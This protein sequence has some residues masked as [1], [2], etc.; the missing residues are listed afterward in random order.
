[1]SNKKIQGRKTPMV[2]PRDKIRLSPTVRIFGK[3]PGYAFKTDQTENSLYQ[4]IERS[5]QS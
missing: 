5:K 3:G 2:I 1:M 4:K